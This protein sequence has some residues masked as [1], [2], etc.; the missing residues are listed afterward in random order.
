MTNLRLASTE[1]YPDVMTQNSVRLMSRFLP[2]KQVLRAV[3]EG[4]R[5][6]ARSPV[7]WSAE[8]NAGFTTG[9]PWFPVNDNYKTVNAADQEADP[10]SLL[11]FY[12]ALL[13]FRKEHPVAL[14]GDYVEL[15]PEDRKLYVYERNY[16]G[17]K[18]L[19]VC[20]FSEDPVRFQAPAGIELDEKALVFGNYSWNFVVANGFTTRPYE[21]RVYLFG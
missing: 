6:N 8:Q 16:E 4:A 3:W 19:V 13:R 9:T 10:D 21:L 17:K 11:N 15:L 12:R 5:D 14:W 7:Q 1:Q 20:S 18:L 2:K